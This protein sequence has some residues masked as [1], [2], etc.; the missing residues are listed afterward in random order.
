MTDGGYGSDEPVRPG[1]EYVPPVNE[2][3]RREVAAP[4]YVPGA[5]SD[6]T[7][8]VT[9]RDRGRA[10]RQEVRRRRRRGFALLALLVVVVAGIG[11]V[12]YRFLLGGAADPDFEGPGVSDVVVE[13]ASGE[14]TTDIAGTLLDEGVVASKGAFLTAAKGNA[15]IE[16]IHPGYYKMRTEISG[17]DAVAKLTAPDARVGAL[18]IPE[19][20]QLADITTV[21]GHVTPGIIRL[22][23][24]ASCVT[25]NERLTCL[26]PADLQDAL[27]STGP[28]EFGVAD[29][30]VDRVLAVQDPLRRYEG[31]IRAGSWDI[32]P[33]WTAAETLTHLFTQSAAGFNAMGLADTK[34]NTGLSPY[35][36][37]IAASLIEREAQPQDF[38]KV[39]RVIINR[40]AVDQQLQF[41][42]TVN[43]AL[44]SQEVATT[45]EDRARVTPWNTY[46][47]HGLPATP[48][49]APGDDAIKA[50]EHPA[51]GDWLYF[52]TTDKDGTTVFTT[53][54]ADHEAAIVTARANGVL[55]S[56]R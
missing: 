27:I 49:S 5:A 55:D 19:G 51:D 47:M 32:D 39:A 9:R 11:V 43:Y 31:L 37:L 29:W 28:V 48:I 30:A 56:G 2:G 41:D 4:V 54:F 12:G 45:D 52:V 15:A 7:Q 33:D 22:V 25:R 20:R 38:D 24:E 26:E 53:D 40:L 10:R 18:V 13:V 34:A 42:S 21:D 35:D 1:N 50:A 44:V 16:S 17:A 14:T 3:W 6:N 46:A 36:T 23:S 8:R